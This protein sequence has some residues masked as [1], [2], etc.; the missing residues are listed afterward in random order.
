MPDLH[1]MPKAE[2][3]P[4]KTDPLVPEVVI[5]KLS[6]A[7]RSHLLFEDIMVEIT[8]KELLRDQGVAVCRKKVMLPTPTLVD[9]LLDVVGEGAPDED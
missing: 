1:D 2:I 3:V 8:V 6:A 5:K 9:W 4:V 7:L